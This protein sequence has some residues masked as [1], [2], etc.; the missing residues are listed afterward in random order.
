MTRAITVVLVMALLLVGGPWVIGNVAEDRVNRGLDQLVDAAPWLGIVDRTYT[1]GWFRSEQ[2]VTFEV[3]G[4]AGRAVGT[5]GRFTVRNEIL[6][7]PLLGW[8]GLGLARV[9]ST[10]VLDAQQRAQVEKIF[11]TDSP[12]TLSTRVG[13]LGGGTTTLASEGRTLR[14]RNGAEVTWDD[15]E[16]DLGYSRDFDTLTIAGDWPRFA[17]HDAR[18]HWD[19]ELTDAVIDGRSERVKGALYSTDLEFTIG[20]LSAAGADLPKTTIEDAHYLVDTAD[21]GD[22]MSV[23]TRLG[24]GPIS[25]GLLAAQGVDLTAIHYDFTLRRLRTNT[26]ARLTEDVSL[27]YRNP[28]AASMLKDHLLELCRF[29]PELLIDRVGFETKAGA[30]TLTGVLRLKG[31]T[32]TDVRMGAL[33][34]LAKLEADLR[35]EAP[36]KLV[37]GFGGGRDAMMN[38][39]DTGYAELKADKVVSRLEFKGGELKINGKVQGIP[40]LG[41][42]PAGPE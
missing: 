12:F 17:G 23:A 21:D 7:G 37:E 40:G 2:E 30:A 8:S 11:G 3:L 35:F 34:M 10:I 6:H 9:N 18:E 42:P 13:F 24:S 31:V 38:A 20:K 26:L 39:V 15:L 41:S 28:A 16:I 36:Q 33:S 1:Q 19:F 32:E 4:G 5:P 25:G 27:S 14:L 29:D 22:F